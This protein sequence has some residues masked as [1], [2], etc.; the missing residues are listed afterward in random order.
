VIVGLTLHFHILGV[1]LALPLLLTGLWWIPSFLVMASPLLLFDLRND[2][3]LTR[4]IIRFV[5]AAPDTSTTLWYRV[6]SY[7]VSLADLIHVDTPASQWIVPVV[8]IIAW[9]LWSNHIHRWIKVTLLLPLVAFLLFRG[10]LV[11]YYAI[12]AWT[13]FVLIAG[14]LL[15]TLWRKSRLWRVIIIFYVGLLSLQTLHQLQS[16]DPLRSI[17]KKLAA[18]RFIKNHA[19]GKTVHVSRTMELS[20]NFGFDYLLWYEGLASSGNP[21]DPTYTL[22]VPARFDGITPDVQFGDIGVVLPE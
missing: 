6:H 3:L 19:N 17:D 10:H 11:P 4:H 1:M 9:G 12:V 18:I 8:L 7:L 5:T 20:A 15:A 2:W 14:T 21:N 16:W 22:V 13:P